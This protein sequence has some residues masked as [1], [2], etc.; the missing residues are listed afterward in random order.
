MLENHGQPT[1]HEWN[2]NLTNRKITALIRATRVVGQFDGI[3]DSTTIGWPWLANDICD[4]RHH[5]GMFT[6]RQHE[7]VKTRKDV[8]LRIK[9]QDA[10]SGIVCVARN[11]SGN[12]E[13]IKLT[14]FVVEERSLEHWS[15][16]ENFI[17]CILIT[18]GCG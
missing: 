1:L 7:I 2:P 6:G 12:D 13:N 5:G 9:R 14:P 10:R 8:S 4:V 3:K 17:R 18:H 15:S 11:D 16:N